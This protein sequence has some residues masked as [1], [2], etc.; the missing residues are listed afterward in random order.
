MNNE[1]LD[2][3]KNVDKSVTLVYGNKGGIG[4]TLVSHLMKS[5]YVYELG[6]SCIHFNH[7]GIPDPYILDSIVE[8]NVSKDM[9]SL[10]ESDD[11]SKD[12]N[13]ILRHLSSDGFDLSSICDEL[14][15]TQHSKAV[16]VVDMSSNDLTYCKEQF[17]LLK[18][19]TT[20]GVDFNLNIVVLL[21]AN[22]NSFSLLQDILSPDFSFFKEVT[23]QFVHT[24]LLGVSSF[25]LI[26]VERRCSY[27][28]LPYMRDFILNPILNRKLDLYDVGSSFSTRLNP[29]HDYKKVSQYYL[30]T[31]KL[32]AMCCGSL[33]VYLESFYNV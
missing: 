10:D 32:S 27:L 11:S 4:K 3:L 19:S 5:Y 2:P 23:I 14:L 15:Y 21:T 16:G 8:P 1:V 26:P 29:V 17:E 7:T 12:S 22:T 6:Y 28:R 9:S 31:H 33:G 18:S 30:S 24:D 25:E 13:S 20:T